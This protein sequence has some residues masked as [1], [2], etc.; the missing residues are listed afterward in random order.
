M[1]EGRQKGTVTPSIRVQT[2]A[3][4]TDT[5]AQVEER[6]YGANYLMPGRIEGRLARFLTDS[7]CTTNLLSKIVFDRLP[8]RTKQTIQESQS[9]GAL[10]DGT[11]LTF[12]GI[13]RLPMRVRN[14]RAEDVFVVSR[15][16]EDAILEVPFLT[17]HNCSLDF[18]LEQL[19][20][21]RFLPLCPWSNC[22][23]PSV[24]HIR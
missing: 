16:C 1:L 2:Y 6:S 23:Y 20:V 22:E 11:Q 21:L 17:A 18:L 14:I 15:V 19:R 24:S 12:Y 4:P 5:T 8:N 10:T 13:I 9:H 3:K 7:G